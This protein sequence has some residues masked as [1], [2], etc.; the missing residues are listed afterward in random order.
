MM[1]HILV[2]DDDEKIR[3]V[4]ERFL[5]GKGYLVNCAADGREGLR[6]MDAEPPDL[7]VT[8]I[9]MPNTDGLEVVLSMRDKHPDIPVVAIS[10][11][12]HAMPMDFLPLVRKFGACKVFYKPVELDDLL[13]GVRELIG[14]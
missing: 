5:R 10:G 14:E 12:M 2:I 3:V 1:K 11:G 7:V 13:E 4:F 8:D 6:R 9:M